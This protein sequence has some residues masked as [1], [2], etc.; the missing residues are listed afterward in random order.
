M[1]IKVIGETTCPGCKKDHEA[2]FDLD[3]LD[4]KKVEVPELRNTRLE[5]VQ[6]EK[7]QEKIVEKIKIPSNIPKYKC[8][9][10]NKNHKNP[11]YHKKPQYKCSN[12]GQFSTTDDECIWCNNKEFDEIDEDELKELGIDEP[13]E[14]EHD[15]EGE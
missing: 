9:N 6:I 12:C 14:E 11:D 15:H 3:K 1:L 8:K 4:I 5:S 7:P 2:E 13:D 10:C